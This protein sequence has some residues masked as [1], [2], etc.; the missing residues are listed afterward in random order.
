MGT[1]L[2]VARRDMPQTPIMS[3]TVCER[4]RLYAEAHQQRSRAVWACGQARQAEPRAYSYPQRQAH[5][6]DL[7]RKATER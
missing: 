3:L 5:L 2:V 7:S 4:T 1:G 6:R